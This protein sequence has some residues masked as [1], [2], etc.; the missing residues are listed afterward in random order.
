MLRGWV[1]ALSSDCC[2][3]DDGAQCGAGVAAIHRASDPLP[4]VQWSEDD[5]QL[6]LT[7]SLIY[8]LYINSGA[9]RGSDRA[10]GVDFYEVFFEVPEQGLCGDRGGF[11]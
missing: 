3:A 9:Y 4:F 7:K 10:W 5:H 2:G 1:C 6:R 11:G 8:Q